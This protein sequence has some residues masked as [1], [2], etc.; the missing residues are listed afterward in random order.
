MSHVQSSGGRPR[1]R[2][3]GA[4]ASARPRGWRAASAVSAASA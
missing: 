4:A 3:K 1:G 2:G